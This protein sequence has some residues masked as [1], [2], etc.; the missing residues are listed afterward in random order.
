MENGDDQPH[1]NLHP[2]IVAQHLDL[3]IWVSI[4]SS[5][6]VREGIDTDQQF[7]ACKIDGSLATTW[8]PPLLK[9]SMVVTY[10]IIEKLKQNSNQQDLCGGVVETGLYN[11]KYPKVKWL[12]LPCA[13]K[14]P[15]SCI[16][17]TSVDQQQY[18][19]ITTHF[20]LN[21]L[22][23]ITPLFHQPIHVVALG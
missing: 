23:Y 12:L 17:V 5:C 19:P 4:N 10:D 13:F 16:C 14:I 15:G 7:I 2:K 20:I 22:A 1:L 6:N 9:S 11:V 18:I 8:L 3:N 21:I